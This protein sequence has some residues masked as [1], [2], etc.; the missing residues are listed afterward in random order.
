MAYLL[1]LLQADQRVT[2]GV[3]GSQADALSMV[4]RFPGLHENADHPGLYRLEP[5]EIPELTEI[6]HAGWVFPL[7]RASFS[8]YPSDGVIHVV[9]N[10]VQIFDEHPPTAGSYAAGNLPLNG[11]SFDMADVPAHV[12]ARELLFEEA[13]TH[14]AERGQVAGREA[15]GSQD[16]EHVTVAPIDSDEPGHLLFLLDLA[17]VYLRAESRSFEDFLSRYPKTCPE[18]P[19]ASGPVK[20]QNQAPQPVALDQVDPPE[21]R[22]LREPGPQRKQPRQERIRLPQRERLTRA[23]VGPVAECQRRRIHPRA[24]SRPGT[25]R[26]VPAGQPPHRRWWSGCTGRP[27]PRP[28]PSSVPP[29]HHVEGSVV[30]RYR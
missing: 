15:L 8:T 16:G 17:A 1:E 12:R 3:F 21:R 23:A 29:L 24:S 5:T 7:C 25:A 18:V 9:W 26:T 13:Q 10:E 6:D 19:R 4:L 11:Y 30:R 27:T 22:L 14:F 28:E 20:L 2:V